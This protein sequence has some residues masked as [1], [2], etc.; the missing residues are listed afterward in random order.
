MG[1]KMT[2]QEIRKLAAMVHA[3]KDEIW[4]K[5]EDNEREPMVYLHWTAGWYGQ[6]FEDYHICIDK[7]GS[8]NITTDDLAEVL[9]HTWQRNSGAIGIALEC[10]VEATSNDNLGGNPPT[11]A[12]IESMATACAI[13]CKEL[14]IS[15]E[16]VMTHAEVA[17]EDDYADERWDLSVINEGDEYGTGGDLIRQRIHEI[18]EE[19]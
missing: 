10:C 15:V 6:S 11:E 19:E 12:Q 5:A 4:E 17:I 16:N 9:A 14:G 3:A 1:N 2:K 7:D 8:L 18:L 13:I